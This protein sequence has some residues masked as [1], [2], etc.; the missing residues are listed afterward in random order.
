MPN[1]VFIQILGGEHKYTRLGGKLLEPGS[2]KTKDETLSLYNRN[3]S[4][5]V[6]INSS[7]TGTLVF[8]DGRR[9]KSVNISFEYDGNYLRI[10]QDGQQSQIPIL[11]RNKGRQITVRLHDRNYD[12]GGT[13]LK[14][15]V[16]WR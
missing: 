5:N 15:I 10:N 13:V 14:L 8:Q 11:N 16:D 2:W 3:L 9:S 1:Q 4:T 6:N 7:S 12:N